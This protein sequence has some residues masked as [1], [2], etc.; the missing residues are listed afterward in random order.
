V[1]PVKL[2]AQGEGIG[3]FTILLSREHV[4]GFS[5]GLTDGVRIGIGV[6]KLLLTREDVLMEPKCPSAPV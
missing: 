3:A 1:A 6:I 5:T 4:K 2:T